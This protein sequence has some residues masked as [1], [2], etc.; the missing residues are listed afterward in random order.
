MAVT[1]TT[2]P[3]RDHR[4]GPATTRG[5]GWPSQAAAVAVGTGLLFVTVHDG[6]LFWLAVRLV[7]VVGLTFRVLGA[8]RSASPAR[9]AGMAF[10]TGLCGVAVGVGIGLPHLNKAGLSLM[11]VAG[12]LALAGGLWL[13]VAGGIGL[14]RA[15]RSWR[16]VIVVPALLVAVVLVVYVFGQA[17]AATNVARTAVGSTTP[18]DRGLAYDDVEFATSDGVQLSGWYVPSTNGAAVVMLHGSGSTRSNLLDRAVVVAGHGYG[19]LLFDARGHGRSDGRA[20]DF[21]WYGDLDTEAAVSF[22]ASRP[23]VDPG[24]IAVL[25]TSMGGEEAIGAAA[26][27]PRIRAV[28]AEGA[29]NRTSADKA[30]LSDVHGWRGT[31]T[32]GIETMVFAAT[33][34]LTSAD[35]PIALRDAATTAAPRP[36]L[37]LAGGNMPDEADAGRYIQ[38]GSP[39]T[40]ELWVV[41]GSGHTAALDTDPGAWEQRVTGFLDEALGV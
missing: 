15:V 27:D 33:D 28:V 6:S 3:A 20:M 40:V 10:A 29:T 14:V 18:G 36:V 38:G 34:L 41:P 7:I 17:L 24:R 35:P 1:T 9:R 37:L 31:I 26:A 23:D 5:A 22:V 4:T 11:T 12:L 39:E 32:E 2:A 25:G 8:L 30:W 21:G 19:V 13:L 16:R